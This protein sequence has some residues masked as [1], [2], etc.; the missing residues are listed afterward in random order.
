VAF[1]CASGLDIEFYDRDLGLEV[2]NV[3]GQ[4]ALRPSVVATPNVIVEGLVVLAECSKLKERLQ[5]LHAD[6]HVASGLESS[7]CILV[8]G[9][10]ADR[11]IF[12][13][14]G[15]ENL[16]ERGCLSFEHWKEMQHRRFIDDIALL[17]NAFNAVD[18]ECGDTKLNEKSELP[19]GAQI[20]PILDLIL[21]DSPVK[22]SAS[23]DGDS[24]TG[25]SN[26]HS[27]PL[28]AVPEHAIYSS[29]DPIL[30]TKESASLDDYGDLH[31]PAWTGETIIGQTPLHLAARRGHEAAV[32]IL[33]DRGANIEA[34]S[35]WSETPLVL[36][37]EHGHEAVV[38]ILLDR[39]ANIE[40]RST[41]LET[42][43]VVAAKH[44][45]EAVVRI[46]L[47]RGANIET[48]STCSETPLVVAANHGHVAVVRILLDR[49]ANIEAQSLWSRTPLLF[50]AEHGHEA[51]VRILLDR[52]ANI[53]AQ[54]IF[55]ETPL[56]VAAEHGH[57][58]VVRI[59]LDRGA[60]IEAQS[61]L[62]ETP[63]ILA[64]RGRHRVVMTLLLKARRSSA[65]NSLRRNMY[66]ETL[67]AILPRECT[68]VAM[69][70]KINEISKSRC[71]LTE[72]F[73]NYQTLWRTGI[74]S[75]ERLSGG[76]LPKSLGETLSILCVCKAMSETMDIYLATS[77]TC[78]FL[79]GLERWIIV[80]DEEEVQAYRH[81]VKAIW[82]IDIEMRPQ[83]NQ[84]GE[85][86]LTPF[87]SYEELLQYAQGLVSCLT[88]TANGCFSTTTSVRNHR[89]SLDQ[90]QRS[91]RERHPNPPPPSEHADPV[92]PKPPDYPPQ[93]QS[94]IQEDILNISSTNIDPRLV[95]LLT[96]AAFIILLL[97]LM[98]KS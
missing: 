29:D 81:I 52:G 53:E 83:D 1:K 17:D 79:R 98:C 28:P 18:Q 37:S 23:T 64:S 60:N 14:F 71:Q 72:F 49:G 42:P 51:V 6:E 13:S 12:A 84:P 33:L 77:Y 59:L 24:Q 45:H 19:S 66:M 78:G 30:S 44:G 70:A 55:S 65:S 90:S 48:R 47:D 73:S 3:V 56:V 39:G 74:R 2:I 75:I 15:L 92:E 26:A 54:S 43:L 4:K 9:F 11:Y 61:T 63:L 93:G 32:R 7:L 46:L 87:E 69:A 35:I 41:W 31:E 95:V 38:R 86:D 82:Q 8:Y 16:Y 62:S 67:H 96:G 80:L 97:F 20:I 27:P 5:S 25:A 91:W 10:L 34:Q 40:T 76:H 36:A 89:A 21:D 50:A 22:P 85:N 68:A 58:A 94:Q 57:E 88:S